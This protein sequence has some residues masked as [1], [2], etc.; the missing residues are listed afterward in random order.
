MTPAERVKQS[1]GS[2][3]HTESQDGRDERLLVLAPGQA[4]DCPS[5]ALAYGVAVPFGQL[6]VACLGPDLPFARISDFVTLDAV[7]KSGT[8]AERPDK[9]PGI[10]GT[11]QEGGTPRQ[12]AV[13]P[14]QTSLSP[15]TSG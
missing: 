1:S 15:S 7:L 11:Q 13:S 3:A 6:G 14:V 9:R 10:H 5:R 8:L 12:G 4:D 2:A